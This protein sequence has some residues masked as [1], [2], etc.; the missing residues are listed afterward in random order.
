MKDETPMVQPVQEPRPFDLVGAIIAHE[1]GELDAAGTQR[2]FQHLVD[3][4][5]AGR[6][7]GSYGRTAQA[8]AEAGLVRP[9]EHGEMPQPSH[10]PGPWRVFDVLTNPEIVTDRPTAHETES[11]VRFDGQ[12]N[13]RAN[14]TLMAA[15]PRLLKVAEAAWTRMAEIYRDTFDSRM[16]MMPTG[17]FPGPRLQ[18]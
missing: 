12:A 18:P 3:T 15:S 11:I 4:G 1:S 13:A 14:A 17:A 16:S 2:L 9:A 10:T 6:L 7:Q 8:L 5:M